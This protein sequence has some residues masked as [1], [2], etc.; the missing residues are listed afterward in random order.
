VLAGVLL[1]ACAARIPEDTRAAAISADDLLAATPLLQGLADPPPL[2]DVQVLALDEDMRG[3]VARHV[4]PA[5]PAVQR[6]EQLLAAVIGNEHFAVVYN[7]RT[8]T[9]AETFR[10][11]EANCLSFTNLF[12]A[13]AR[14]AGITVSYQEVD[15]PPDWTLTGDIM[16][17]SRHV[18]VL[19]PG[20][21][22]ADRVVDFNMAD[23]DTAYDRRAITDAR[24]RAHYYSN[25]GA[26]HLQAGEVLLA[27]RH[28][29]KALA[30]D[31]GFSPAWVNLGALYLRAGEPDWA[32]AA[33]R[34][35]LAVQP[36]EQA[37]MSNLER[38]YREHGELV[39]AD[40]LRGR[41]QRYRA[42]NPYYLYHLA[43][44]AYA[45]GEYRAAIRNLRYALR[46]KKTE[47]RFMALMGL[48][49]LRLGDVDEARRW[50]TQAEALADDSR[51]REGYHGKLEMLKAL[52]SG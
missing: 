43:Q 46:M 22:G 7:D 23:F 13:L 3:F 2:A 5:A 1:A 16:V 26:A 12:I 21:A 32:R 15:V 36:D 45:A 8:Y 19:V 40:E 41:I 27:L 44:Q 35:A 34:Q 47:D 25:L 42:Q 33:W 28:L 51:Q 17:L 14:E 4:D 10:L 38:L 20:R 11:K 9:A 39:A 50:F 30:E 24:G 52:N 49:Y 18:D 48:S 6:L 29:R 37:A 31:P